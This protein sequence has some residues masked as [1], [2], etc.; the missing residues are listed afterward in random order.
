VLGLGQVPLKSNRQAEAKYVSWR[1][2]QSLMQ[3]TI[4]AIK[5]YF[6]FIF[7]YLNKLK[8]NK[9]VIGNHTKNRRAGPCVCHQAAAGLN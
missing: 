1:V 8:I 4:V 3:T 5:E 7:E 6:E 2:E 9:K